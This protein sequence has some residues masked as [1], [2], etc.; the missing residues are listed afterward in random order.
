VAAGPH[1]P[2]ELLEQGLYRSQVQVHK[3]VHAE[4]GVEGAVLEG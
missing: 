3:D 1:D 4:G 2:V